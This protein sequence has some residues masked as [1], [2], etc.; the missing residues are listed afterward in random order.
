MI[1]TVGIRQLK[2]QTSELVRQVRE[3]G[4]PIQITHHGKV[5]ALLI[6][7]EKSS[8]KEEQDKAWAAL[9]ELALRISRQWPDGVSAEQA[10]SEDRE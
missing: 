4:N 2:Q 7:T 6:S 3:T 10:I 8:D 1:K 9:D 5:V